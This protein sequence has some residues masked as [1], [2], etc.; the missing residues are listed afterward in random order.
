MRVGISR[1]Y[2]NWKS[3]LSGRFKILTSHGRAAYVAGGLVL[4]AVALINLIGCAKPDAEEVADSKAEPPRRVTSEGQEWF[5]NL[6]EALAEAKRS[7]KVVLVD[8]SGIDWCKPCETLR[9]Q[10]F[11]STEFAMWASSRVILVAINVPDPSKPRDAKV[12]ELT[13]RYDLTLFPTVHF[14]SPEGTSLGSIEGGFDKAEDWLKLAEPIVANS[15]FTD[16]QS[17]NAETPDADTNGADTNG[18]D[19]NGADQTGTETSGKPTDD[20]AGAPDDQP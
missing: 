11:E 8:F 17:S 10:V 2:L 1:G 3:V 12:T 9:Q 6:D 16:S 14:L 19:A 20:S 15:Q 5:A 7:E 4:G 13:D 18:A